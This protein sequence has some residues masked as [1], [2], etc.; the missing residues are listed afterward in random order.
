MHLRP[1]FALLV[2]LLLSVSLTIPAEDAPETSYDESEPLPFDGISV[3]SIAGAQVLESAFAAR[4]RGTKSIRI[5]GEKPE[6]SLSEIP[7]GLPSRTNDSITLLQ[8]FRC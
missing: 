3:T 4:P 8:S 2:I 6:I 5:C 1:F 7:A